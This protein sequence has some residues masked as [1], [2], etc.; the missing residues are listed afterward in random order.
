MLVADDCLLAALALVLALGPALD[1][2]LELLATVSC[3]EISE[4][5]NKER[6]CGEPIS[7]TA[8]GRD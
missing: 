7:M 3:P 2:L 5:K 6:T 4:N 8:H 1:P